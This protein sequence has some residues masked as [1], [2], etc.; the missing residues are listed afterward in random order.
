MTFPI[1]VP[2]RLALLLL[3]SFW[4]TASLRGGEAQ[5]RIG[6]QDPWTR[7]DV[8]LP[9][10]FLAQKQSGN[11]PYLVYQVGF[12]FLYKAGHIPGS[13]YV[14][15]GKDPEGIEALKKA[16]SALPKDQKILLYCGCCPPEVCPNLRPAFR[17]VKKLGFTNAKILYLPHDFAEDWIHKG[18]PTEKGR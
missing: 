2:S 6:P 16:V 17:T 10:E 9:E 12:S 8:L 7:N 1:S 3:C 4:A 18:Y 14:G 15:A 5:I 11:S 13:T